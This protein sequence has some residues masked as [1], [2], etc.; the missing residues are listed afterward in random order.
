MPR[1]EQMPHD[2]D[3]SVHKEHPVMVQAEH[4]PNDLKEYPRPQWVCWRQVPREEGKKP[5]KKPINPRTLGN[6]GPHWPNSWSTFDTAYE[7]YLCHH[8]LDDPRH[9]DGVG[10]FLTIE[11]PFTAVDLDYCITPDGI[12]KLAMEIIQTLESYSESSPSGLGVRILVAT[13]APTKAG[14]LYCE[15]ATARGET[16]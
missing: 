13:P 7:T 10:F 12:T 9:L 1:L 2:R 4:I 5:D 11:D 3:P 15:N 14:Y 8:G 16:V 6:A